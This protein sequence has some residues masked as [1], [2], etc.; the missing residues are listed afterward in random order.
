LIVRPSIRAALSKTASAVIVSLIVIG[1]ISVFW[2]IKIG[3]FN[4]LME[5]GGSEYVTNST[6]G[7]EL[8]IFCAGSLYLP[9]QQL[10][11][12]YESTH[13]GVKVYI[14][15]SGSVT[16]VRK[17]T[18]LGKRADILALA[19]YRLVPKFMMNKY[20]KWVI[21][22]A[23]NRLV[24][25]YTNKSRY[26]TV[27]NSTNWM[28]ILM[29]PDV[30]FGFSNPNDDPC[31]YRAVTVLGLASLKYGKRVLNELL[32]NETNVKAQTEN[33]ILHLYI[34]PNLKVAGDKLVI[35]SKSVDLVALVESG[36][37]DYAFEYKSVAVQHHLDY[38]ELP[39]ELSL[40]NPNLTI[41][42]SK[43]V[44]HLM[45]G[46]NQEKEVKGY[47]I[48]YGVTIPSTAK[49]IK[50]ALEFIKLLLSPE[51]EE[52]F[53]SLGQSYIKPILVG[54]VPQELR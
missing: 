50:G 45:S 16:A 19:D 46:T 52:I 11:K 30:R 47:P 41:F 26:S 2:G 42:Y 33:G 43:V 31:G 25:V 20:A 3:F 8:V 13:P 44:V 40:N 15:P 38:V 49:N 18:D 6:S 32:L 34:P 36:V 51:G 22:F 10:S 4:S 7:G 27:I 12:I 29:K 35:R 24:L 28:K 5:R 17:V 21:G 53:N 14:E 48:I 23:T 1:L 37:I 54:E 39:D 9:L